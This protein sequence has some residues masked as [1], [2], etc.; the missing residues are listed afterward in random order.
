MT[1]DIESMFLQVSVDKSDQ[2][3]LRFLWRAD[4]Q[5]AI[6]VFQYTRHNFGAKSSPTC[7]NFAL[8][9]CAKD[10]SDQT[11]VAKN[12]IENF[13]MDDLLVS[14]K[15]E[16][17]LMGIKDGLSSVLQRG[18]FNLTKWVNNVRP[19]EE[20]AKEDTEPRQVIVLGIQ[21]NVEVDKLQ[22][23]RGL[24]QK[25]KDIWTQGAIL[26]V[27]SSVYDPLICFAPFTVV[28]RI[29]LK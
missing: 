11:V 25:R 12:I 2:S 29:I 1:A 8:Q 13:Y 15:I 23:C 18:G 14:C 24:V 9:Q 28:T 4:P 7:A 16:Q 10:N 22:L 19:Q 21:W 6:G 3:L 5:D 17:E 27:V 26:S 20:V